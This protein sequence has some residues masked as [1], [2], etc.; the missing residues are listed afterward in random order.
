[1]ENSNPIIASRYFLQKA[2][3]TAALLL[4]AAFSPTAT[5][6]ATISMG[7]SHGCSVADT[8]QITCWGTLAAQKPDAAWFTDIKV[9]HDF[10][11]ALLLSSGVYC[12]GGNGFSQLGT[13]VQTPPFGPTLSGL[14][15]ANKVATGARHACALTAEG[16]VY[17]WG[18]GS[19][20]QIG[21]AVAG[22]TAQA[23]RVEGLSGM[24][25][26]AAGQASTC[27][28]GR[29]RKVLCVGSGSGLA[30]AVDDPR[31]PRPVPG[32]IDALDIALF[33]GHACVIRLQG[34]VSCWGS[35]RNGELG[36]PASAGV[37]T[38]P[39]EVPDL[40]SS[41]KAVAVGDGYTCVLLE[42][43][44][45][46]C[47]GNSANG[48]L[49]MGLASGTVTPA[50]G[51]VIGV[52][53]ATAISAGKTA[54]CAVLKG[55]YIQCWGE[56]TGWSSA[57]CRVPGG[58][59]PGV[60][61]SYGPI[62]DLTICR[63]QG[64]AAPMA[65]KGLGPANDAAQVLDWAEK[66]FPQTFPSQ[67]S[68]A[69][70]STENLYLREYP[71]GHRLAINVHGTP[72]LI[73]A[74]P[75]SAGQ[76]ADLGPLHQWINEAALDEGL[77]SGLQLQAATLTNGMPGETCPMLQTRYGIRGGSSVLPEGL[78][79]SSVKVTGRGQTVE[80]LT[81]SW[82]RK[83]ARTSETDW[84]SDGALVPGPG[85]KLEP[86]HF[87]VAQGCSAFIGLKDDVDVVVFYTIGTRKG[88]LRTKTPMMT[89]N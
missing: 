82:Y 66:A 51:L 28:V 33:D 46:K 78:M 23:T 38:T 13:P 75:L 4:P 81:R 37:V 76:M 67:T 74:G 29:D 12:W 84:L 73:Y 45:V 21:K 56:G 35:N 15:Q 86:V 25:A 14:P 85:T 40:G 43:G 18:D 19:Q 49:G 68:T 10:S 32:V 16:E 62:V 47:W 63:P 44:T 17:C 70:N 50:A 53:D 60:P 89:S 42:G 34:K 80:H 87:G 7:T 64:S 83:T 11:C 22:T 8:A 30:S 59:Y 71:E 27:A 36:L 57:Q 1:M 48:Q 26:I 79:S 20:G 88:A 3:A 39:V 77:R 41:A 65:V 31:T 58:L 5:V 69:A 55:N 6:A 52:T 9:G 2:L 54:A 61:A 72:H 24:V